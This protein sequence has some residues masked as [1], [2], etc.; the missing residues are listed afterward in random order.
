MAIAD[1]LSDSRGALLAAS[2]D[3]VIVAAS[4]R[5]HRA[6][7]WLIDRYR[8]GM[9]DYAV[10]N[11]APDPDG[12]VDL[13]MTRVLRRLPR[14]EN[15]SEGSLET[16]LYR[17]LRREINREVT[18]DRNRRPD[19]IDLRDPEAD[20]TAPSFEDSIDDAALLE[21]LLDGLSEGQRQVIVE[22]FINE[23][24]YEELSVELGQTSSALRKTSSR[25]ISKLRAALAV[26]IAAVAVLAVVLLRTPPDTTIEMAPVDGDSTAT[27]GDHDQTVGIDDGSDRSSGQIVTD[28][29]GD[30]STGAETGAD[31]DAG[32]DRRADEGAGSTITVPGQATTSTTPGAP[33]AVSPTDPPAQGVTDVP[34]QPDPTFGQDLGIAFGSMTFNRPNGSVLAPGERLELTISIDMTNGRE[35]TIELFTND[36]AAVLSGPSARFSQSTTVVQWVRYDQPGR[37]DRLRAVA[38]D[39]QTG[40]VVASQP[41]SV[42]FDWKAAADADDDADDDD[43][44][45]DDRDD[46]GDDQDGSD[47]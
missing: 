17:S 33:T 7:R 18:R 6:I 23:R 11:R 42:L 2:F 24:T 25:A 12:V 14:L 10:R 19:T 46:D 38:R 3:D 22:H 28:A 44:G 40:E 45:D 43:D 30:G 15:V 27:D 4:E 16:Y 35:M 31:G 20:L 8:D 39:V 21:S 47:D 1:R 37:L 26:A 32:T 34:L 36:P 9:V 13:V 5:D 29:E 41:V